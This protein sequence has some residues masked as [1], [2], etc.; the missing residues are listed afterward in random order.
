MR[1]LLVTLPLFLGLGL[2]G[3][4][5]HP[6]DLH[7]Q[8]TDVYLNILASGAKKLNIAIPE[9]ARP[10]GVDP[11]GFAK[12]LPEIVGNDL[13]FS[14]LFSVVSGNAPLPTAPEPLKKALADLQAAGA[15]AALQGSLTANGE[16]LIVE[17][18]LLD[19]TAPEPRPIVTKI[20]DALARDHRRMAHKIADE[21]VYQFTGERGIADTKI[22]YVSTS[23]GTKEIDMMDYDG[24]NV[25]QLTKN[26]SINLSP[27]WRP[28]GQALA[29]TSY[30]REFPQLFLLLPYEGRQQLLQGWPGLNTAPAWSPDGQSLAYT[31]SKD[32]NPEIYVLRTRTGEIRR[33]TNHRGIDTDPTWS[34]TGREIAFTSDRGGT[35][36]IYIADAEGANVRRLTFEGGYN[37]QPRWSSRGAEI[38]Y[39]SRQG[40][41]DLWAINVD[42]SNLRRLTNGGGNESPSWAP[43]GRHVVFASRRTGRWQLFT[44]LADGNDVRQLT[45]DRGEATGPAWSPRIP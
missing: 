20:Y 3:V 10:Q 4:L 17:V 38:V 2:L 33:L 42:G 1:R 18:R 29:F 21:V 41:F 8:A 31:L 22:A 30:Q 39:T 25:V 7:P 12:R 44:M 19:L 40:T 28:D 11:Q 23:S 35:P 45:Q 37:V 15:H 5:A 36:Q 32:G 43:N 26:G 27:A 16:K 13:T 24:F 9:F 14:A 6:P 34:P